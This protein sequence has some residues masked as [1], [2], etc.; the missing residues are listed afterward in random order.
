MYSLLD[1]IIRVQNHMVWRAY[2][3]MLVHYLKKEVTQYLFSFENI[4][5]NS[6]DLITKYSR[7]IF[8]FVVLLYFFPGTIFEK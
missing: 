5:N 7:W 8:Y 3:N 2:L 4:Q 6:H 1:S